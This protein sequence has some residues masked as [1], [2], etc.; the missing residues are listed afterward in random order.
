MKERILVNKEILVDER[1]YH[2]KTNSTKKWGSKE[3]FID[4]VDCKIC[5]MASSKYFKLRGQKE[6]REVM[7]ILNNKIWV[8]V[9]LITIGGHNA[10]ENV[11]KKTFGRNQTKSKIML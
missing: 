6:I 3:W 11:V 4:F 7:G 1:E 8:Y 5:Y 2:R 10:Y 9:A